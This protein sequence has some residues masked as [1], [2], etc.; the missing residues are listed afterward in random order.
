MER[1]WT[2]RNHS[3]EGRVKAGSLEYIFTELYPDLYKDFTHK[4]RI[5]YYH[6]AA[7]IGSVDNIDNFWLA[8]ISDA[9]QDQFS[10]AATRFLRPI[11][12]D[13]VLFLDLAKRTPGVC[14]PIRDSGVAP[15]SI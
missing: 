11:A 15:A 3:D 6:R 2:I 10:V 13:L 14:D 8:W 1:C 7:T 4:I 12:L 9:D 5:N